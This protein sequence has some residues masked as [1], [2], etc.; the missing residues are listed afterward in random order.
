[1]PHRATLPPDN[2]ATDLYSPVIHEDMQEIISHP[3]AWLVR[4]GTAVLLAIVGGVLLLSYLTWYPEQLSAPMQ[5]TSIAPPLTI[6]ARTTGR[7]SQVLVRDKQLVAK[8]QVL[9]Y[10]ETIADPDQVQQLHMQLLDL[11]RQA[12]Q[13]TAS[14]PIKEL[15]TLTYGQLGELEDKFISFQK[16]QANYIIS[17]G[18]GAS[19][20]ASA[21]QRNFNTYL[22]ALDALRQ[23][24]A[25]W[26]Q[27]NALVA[28]AAGQLRTASALGAGQEVPAQQLL[29]YLIPKDV[30]KGISGDIFITPAQAAT[31]HE[32]QAVRV[33]LSGYRAA[34]TELVRGQ[35]ATIAAVPTERGTLRV[36]IALPAGLQ[37]S[38]RITLPYH[39]GMQATAE[40]TIRERRFLERILPFATT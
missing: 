31:L 3:P 14:T 2:P 9:A 26:L 8:G 13:P 5:L 17:L 11:R 24:I 34:K 40:I 10:M 12:S 15:S 35:I 33:R 23:D 7:L 4:W 39:P 21:Q 32:G 25:G 29:F 30:A 18:R 19:L 6:S 27:H 37:T 16:A 22:Q 28:P 1:M 36:Q 20:P 38:T